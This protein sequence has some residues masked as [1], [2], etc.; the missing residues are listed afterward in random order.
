MVSIYNP[1]DKVFEV[2]ARGGAVY[3]FL[4]NSCKDVEESVARIAVAQHPQLQVIGGELT[5]ED[6]TGETEDEEMERLE[7]EIESSESAVDV[8][9][10]QQPDGSMQ[11]MQADDLKILGLN[12]AGM[13]YHCSHPGCQNTY[14]NIVIFKQ[15]MKAHDQKDRRELPAKVAAIEK[16]KPGRK[17]KTK[18]E[19]SNA[20]EH[21]ESNAKEGSE[22][23]SSSKEEEVI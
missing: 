22:E 14:T 7:R 18:Y 10:F 2:A 5:M 3:T 16:K 9:E 19:N 12:T 17:P 23:S 20:K 11:I 15:H 4:D 8:V 1:T 6:K 13:E 21:E